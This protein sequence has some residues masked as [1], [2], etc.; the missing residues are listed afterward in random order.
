[1]SFKAP[2]SY[3]RQ[4]RNIAHARKPT[5]HAKL[6]NLAYI[7][8]QLSSTL[9]GRI[10]GEIRQEIYEYALLGYL[11]LDR[12]YD[13]HTFHYR[14]GYTH[15]R[16]INTNLLL[17]CRRVYLEVGHLA[18][19]LNE[20]LIYQPTDHGPPGHRP[21]LL[22]HSKAAKGSARQR[23]GLLK[24]EQR[25]AIQY[26]HI[27]AQQHWLEGWNYQ[28]S[29]YCKSWS[30]FAVPSRTEEVDPNGCDHPPSL[31]ITIRHTDWWYFLLGRHSPLALDAKRC[32]RAWPTRWVP[33]EEPF[34]PGSWGS[35]FSRL[36]GLQTFELEM[37][38]ITS[39][40]QEL[41][42]VIDKAK[43]WRFPLGDGNVLLCDRDAVK[44]ETWTGSKHFR[45]QPANLGIEP[46]SRSNSEVGIR[47]A[48]ASSD[49]ADSLIGDR[50][51]YVVVTLVWRAHPVVRKQDQTH[52]AEIGSDKTQEE[53]R[54]DGTSSQSAD[55]ATEQL[56]AALAI[57]GPAPPAPPVPPAP[58]QAPPPRVG[59]FA[60]N[61]ARAPRRDAI[62]TYYG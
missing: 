9:F 44:T 21:Y 36:R 42:E 32:G 54:F 61:V 38:T 24:L 3:L 49:H 48:T 4:R 45:S 6:H 58:A 13:Q 43:C 34:E 31:K 40:R 52:S 37:E 12:P 14:P 59:I 25:L 8:P 11:D 60:H 27:F 62:P 15:A 33:E 28:W 41:H 7:N 57:L 19:S 26:V 39:K 35:Q 53:S 50:L 18:V 5:T 55:N 20:H 47:D 2:I 29:E 46:S 17:T 10:P 22:P 23:R 16:A 1:M 51:D 30:K 56:S